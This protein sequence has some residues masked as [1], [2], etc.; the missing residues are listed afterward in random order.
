MHRVNL[1][2]LFSPESKEALNTARLSQKDSGANLNKLSLL[3][4]G[5]SIKI[6]TVAKNTLNM[7]NCINL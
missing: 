1:S 7:F 3:I 4:F 6:T 2:Y 5:T